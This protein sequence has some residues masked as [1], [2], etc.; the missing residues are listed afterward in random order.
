MTDLYTRIGS[1]VRP[2]AR[3]QMRDFAVLGAAGQV[4]AVLSLAATAVL[5]RLTGAAGAGEV[6]LAQSMAAVWALLCDPRL[7]DAAQRFVPVQE[8]GDAG[9]GTWLFR[10][11]L[12]L[13]A[14]IGLAGAALGVTLVTVAGQAGAAPPGP[15]S[16]LVLALLYQGGTA[17]RGTSAAGFAIAG[18]LEL[19]GRLRL[20]FAVLSCA[21]TV[22]AL[23][24]GGP[25]AY[26]AAMA[27]AAAVTTAVLAVLARRA[28]G[29][30]LG[31]APRG[32][33]RAPAGLARFAVT[34]SAATCVSLA[35]DNGI[36]T[37]AG[38]LGG[39]SLVTFLKIA[40]APGRL[41]LATVSTV[42]AQLY[43]RLASAAVRGDAG[44]IRRDVLRAT[45]PLTVLGVAAAGLALPLARPALA[46]VYGPA[47]VTLATATLVLL[48]AGCVRGA[49][50]WAKVLPLAVGRPAV[51]LVAVATEG[52][53]LTGALLLALH[54]TAGPEAA[55]RAYALGALAVAVLF[56][57][58]W[59]ALLR[60][61]AG[62]P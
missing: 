57:A 54:L 16:L 20:G 13:D 8:A 37:L 44:A 21:A 19:L 29:A 62:R 17:S 51:R 41:F 59:L 14:L 9:G 4:E 11:L 23:V 61:L 58:G 47:Y 26:L 39:P 2:S 7:G 56:A 52:V 31:P 12:R 15:A 48:A 60:P 55:A 43:P 18:K 30:K 35:S 53:L 5:V 45:V 24:L 22:T 3:R 1:W 32:P 25:V 49:V 50:V 6:L 40:A 36:L 28:V 27:S 46:L 42:T 34:T 33:R 10:R 38:L